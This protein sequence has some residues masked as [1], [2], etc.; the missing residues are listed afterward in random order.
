MNVPSC[1][2]VSVTI[3]A[4]FETQKEVAGSVDVD[5]VSATPCVHGLFN[6]L[7]SFVDSRYSR[8]RGK[9]AFVFITTFQETEQCEYADFPIQ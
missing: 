9:T 5:T 6:A 3:P 8:V 4:T 2:G 7:L 1:F